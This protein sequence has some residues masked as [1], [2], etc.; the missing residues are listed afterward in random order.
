MDI[1][2]AR[3][4]LNI[5]EEDDKAAIK[6]KYRRLM[7][8]YHPD[9]VGSDRP[10]HV[11]RAQELNEAYQILQRKNFP[12]TGKKK[13]EWMG[14]VN[15]NAFSAR[16]IYLYYSMENAEKLYYQA[17]RGKYMW[18]PGEE[19]FHLFLS[20]IHHLSKEI[21]EKSEKNVSILRSEKEVN[22]IRFKVQARLV[23]M[24]A[25]QFIHPVKILQKWEKSEKGIYCFPAFLGTKGRSRTFRALE[26][27]KKGECLIPKSFQDNRIIAADCGGEILGHLSFSE[28]YLYFLIIPLLKRKMAQVKI[29]VRE[30]EVKKRIHPYS[31]RVVLDFYFRLEKNAEH[32]EN[33]MSNREIDSLLKKYAAYLS[34]LA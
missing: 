27:L 23:Y 2:K 13:S 5:S 10:E 6:K 25:Q 3:K 9:A 32:Y 16:S 34:G 12:K 1:N 26:Q 8:Q 11:R 17:A 29:I 18:D 33:S 31:I 14:E 4:I 7:G 24:L 21:L 30:T 15:E 20:S 22:E 19:D 28:D